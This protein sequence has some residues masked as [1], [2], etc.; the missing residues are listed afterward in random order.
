MCLSGSVYDGYGECNTITI[1]K[2]GPVSLTNF[3]RNSNSMEITFHSHLHSKTVIATRFCTWQDSCAV[4]AFAKICYD[5]MASNGVMARRSFHRIWFAGKKTLVTPAPG[6]IR[7][8]IMCWKHWDILFLFYVLCQ[9]WGLCIHG[10]WFVCVFFLFFISLSVRPSVRLSARLFVRLS[11]CLSVFLFSVKK[12]TV[13]ILKWFGEIIRLGLKWY[14]EQL[15]WTLN[16]TLVLSLF[17]PN[18]HCM[19]QI[20]S[21]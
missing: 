1:V 13:K 19:G 7:P 21:L 6:V 17:W 20:L 10:R 5:L 14:K 9:W 3:H 2:L 15:V 12:I 16:N 4:V 8:V 18:I 11:A